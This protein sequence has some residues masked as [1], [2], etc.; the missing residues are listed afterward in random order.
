VGSVRREGGVDTVGG[1]GGAESV[2]AEK[3]ASGGAATAMTA[4]ARNRD[5][6][7]CKRFGYVDSVGEK[8]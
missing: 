8:K 2:M 4:I 6:V 1:E 5:G 7:C 3:A